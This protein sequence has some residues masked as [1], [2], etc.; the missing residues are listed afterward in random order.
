VV[1]DVDPIGGNVPADERVGDARIDC[2]V[3]VD[4]LIEAGMEVVQPAALVIVDLGADPQLREPV[5]D[6]RRQVEEVDGAVPGH[7]SLD[8]P[9]ADEVAES[10]EV[11]FPREPVA[12]GVE[13]GCEVAAS[14]GGGPQVRAMRFQRG[15]EHA[16]VAEAGQEVVEKPLGSAHGQEGEKEEHGGRAG[17][18]RREI[19]QA[20][21][22]VDG[23]GANGGARCRLRVQDPRPGRTGPW[24]GICRIRLGAHRRRP[25]PV[26]GTVSRSA[27]AHEGRR[28]P[29]AGGAG[30][31]RSECS[32]R[33]DA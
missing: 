18:R 14:I 15:D 16:A 19:G 22:K 3:G 21:M 13:L 12:Q 4:A 2:Q 8:P 25:S 10:A 17:I 7:Q 32:R 9:A 26:E 27:S 30:M 5:S 28:G 29:A 6:L 33:G 23:V 1:D 20:G 24:R 11:R 31:D